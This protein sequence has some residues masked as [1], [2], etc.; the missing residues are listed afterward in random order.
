MAKMIFVCFVNAEFYRVVWTINA[1]FTVR[2]EMLPFSGN[3]QNIK[4]FGVPPNTLPMI[5][6]HRAILQYVIQNNCTKV[7]WCFLMISCTFWRSRKKEKLSNSPKLSCGF[8]TQHKFEL[9]LFL[10]ECDQEYSF[11]SVL[12]SGD[13]VTEMTQVLSQI[14]WTLQSPH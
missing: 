14:S 13:L 3:I 9:K 11:Y 10:S 12:F 4:M 2:S 6:C 7:W 1:L 5:F 8:N